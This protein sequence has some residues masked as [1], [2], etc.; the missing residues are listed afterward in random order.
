[1]TRASSF[2]AGRCIAA[3]LSACLA[4]WCQGARPASGAPADG[5]QTSD[6]NGSAAESVRAEADKRDSGCGAGRQG[7]GSAGDRAPGETAEAAEG[8]PYKYAGNNF[9]RKFHRPSCLFARAMNAQH[10][11]LFHFRRQAVAAGMRPC[12]WC[13]PPVWKE[14]RAILRPAPESPGSS[15]R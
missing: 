2:F 4:L 1:M 6:S 8:L 11:E 3:A 5:L 10:L 15:P 12:R 14:V 13:L 7:S 9:S